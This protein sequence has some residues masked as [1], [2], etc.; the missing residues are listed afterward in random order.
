MRIAE[1]AEQ[2]G[3]TPSTLRYYERIGLVPAPARTDSG[4]RDYGDEAA[5]RLRFVCRARRIGLTL[6][7]ITEVLPIWDGVHCGATHERISELVEEKRAEILER[8]EELHAFVTQLDAVH[9][10][11]AESPP[12]T[13]CRPDLSCCVPAPE[14]SLVALTSGP[15]TSEPAPRQPI[16]ITTPPPGDNRKEHAMPKISKQ[17]APEFV[18]LEGYEGRF[19]Q[20]LDYTV[21]F[22]TYTADADLSELF[23]GL[24]DDRCQCPHFGVVLKGKLK[25]MGPDG[26]TVVEA[27]EAYHVPPGHTPFLYAGTEVVEFSPTVKLQETLAV[28]ERNMAA[29]T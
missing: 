3:V 25:F 24:P 20:L 21:G 22:E 27:G 4:Y 9:D 12:P 17:D 2:L 11:L 29:A 23:K 13:A 5:A 26:D 28:V 10:A 15:F 7:Q 18:E 1:V 16:E 8:I 19:G 6:E 14:S